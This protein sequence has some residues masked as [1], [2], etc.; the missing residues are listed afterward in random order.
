MCRSEGQLLADCCRLRQ[1]EI[2]QKPPIVVMQHSPIETYILLWLVQLRVKKR[3]CKA[4]FDKLHDS[5]SETLI[6]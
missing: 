2:G 6:I 5:I 3:F 1:A 4:V